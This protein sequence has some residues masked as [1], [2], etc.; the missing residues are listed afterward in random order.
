MLLL[1]FVNR[2]RNATLRWPSTNGIVEK[3]SNG[4]GIPMVLYRYVVDGEAYEGNAILVGLTA[5]TGAGTAVPER[6]WVNGDG[7]LKFPTGASVELFYNPA[8]PHDAVLVTGGASGLWRMLLPFPV[9]GLLW[10]AFHYA[11]VLRQYVWV[12]MGG[13]VL[14]AFVGVVHLVASLRHRRSRMRSF[15]QTTGCLTRAEVGMLRNGEHV[16]YQPEVE[17]RYEVN[18]VT[19]FCRQLYGMQKGRSRRWAEALVEE[20]KRK[21]SLEVWYDS[22]RPWDAV[23]LKE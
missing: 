10:G 5:K 14:G 16:S 11:F 20:L 12:V 1:W 9:V 13:M 3:F 2:R 6:F 7:A 19:Y 18:G 8:N 22:Q 15:E 23:L 21:E 17:Y 4:Y